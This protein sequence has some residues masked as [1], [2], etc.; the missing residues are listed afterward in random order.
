MSLNQEYNWVD[1]E[2]MAALNSLKL[3]MLSAG[4]ELIDL[5]MINPDLEPARLLLDRLV[6]A[7]LKPKANRYS[8]A[9][10]VKKLREAFAKKYRACG[11]DLDSESQ[12]CVTLGT[13]D[14]LLDILTC[15]TGKG[16]SVLVGAPTYPAYNFL[17]KLLGLEVDFF[18]IVPDEKEMLA[19]I[20]EK[21]A[22]RDFRLILLN[23]P[24]NPTGLT[25]TAD[26][27]AQLADRVNGSRT[28]IVND[29]VYGEM[30]YDR[31][32]AVSLL[33]AR[34]IHPA[35]VETYSLSKAYSVPGWRIGAALGEVELIARIQKLKSKLDYG[36]FMPLQ[37]AAAAAL[38]SGD[39]L[40]Q[41][42]TETYHRRSRLLELGL[43]P[44]GFETVPARAGASVWSK[45]PE[46]LTVDSIE[47]S[48]HLLKEARVVVSPGQLF[49][50][51]YGRFLR[52]ALVRPEFELQQVL[53]LIGSLV[54][55]GEGR[56]NGKSSTGNAAR[57]V[58]A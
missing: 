57:A 11:I 41:V 10:G 55:V 31:R 42:A 26:F 25:V 9:R 58:P 47:F 15:A 7:T 4:E 1:H 13:K 12:V 39:D 44:L 22:K 16:D 40:A 29:F 54:N 18:E 21:L 53:N 52:F 33:G 14:A 20:F 8:V 48:L 36:I 45:I 43:G 5:S 23:F 56:S 24:N 49:G 6:E 19:Q 17:F 35:L 38:G 30:C 50:K 34:H 37:L 3:S 46:S 2:E 51:G 27:F 32:Q 28:R